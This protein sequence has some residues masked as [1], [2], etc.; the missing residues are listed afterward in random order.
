MD[1]AGECCKISVSKH[2]FFLRF[3]SVTQ[4]STSS[5]LQL[6]HGIPLSTT[7]HR[8]FLERQHWQAFE[9]RLFT[10]R[11]LMEGNPAVADFLLV[12]PVCTDCAML[13]V[14]MLSSIACNVGVLPGL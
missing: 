12:A 7:S 5:N 14:V 9:A 3:P 4:H 8:T 11:V 1:S 6:V 13:A 2:D 10:G